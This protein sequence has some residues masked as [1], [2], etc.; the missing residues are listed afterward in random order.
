M[1]LKVIILFIIIFIILLKNYKKINLMTNINNKTNSLYKYFDLMYVIT[2]PERKNSMI[3]LFSKYKLNPIYYPAKLKKDINY[4]DLINE[5]FIIKEF[6]KS[7]KK[8]CIIFEDDNN[9]DV[10][11]EEFNKTI[12]NSMKYLPVNWDIIY[13]S[14][15]FDNCSK[16]IHI[17]NNLYKVFFPTCRNAYAITRKCAEILIKNTIPMIDNGDEMYKILIKKHI[18]NAYTIS[19]NLLYQNREIYGTTLENKQKLSE[20]NSKLLDLI[21]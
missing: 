4:N 19:P 9:I 15:C 6:L 5:G 16:Q 2:L 3:E 21:N 13:F 17:K 8:T 10:S 7:N 20:C 1:N 18:I 12:D 14:R 11:L